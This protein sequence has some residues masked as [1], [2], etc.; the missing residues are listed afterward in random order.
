M[1]IDCLVKSAL[2][3][4][5][6]STIVAGAVNSGL[7]LDDG[8]GEGVGVGVGDESGAA[9]GCGVNTGAGVGVG[10]AVGEGCGVGVADGDEEG[11]GE[12]LGAPVGLADGW[13]EPTTTIVVGSESSHPP[14]ASNAAITPTPPSHL[15]CRMPLNLP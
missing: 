3:V 6:S 2:L 8:V 5:S 11:V 14:V 9:V 7:A 13:G 15:G 1:G 10:C 12:P 4:G